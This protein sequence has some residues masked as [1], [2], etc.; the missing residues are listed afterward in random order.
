M[1]IFKT[2][3]DAFVHLFSLRFRL[4]RRTPAA[5]ED[6]NTLFKRKVIELVAY[7]VQNLSYFTTA[8]TH[9]SA[10]DFIDKKTFVSNE[11]LEFLGDAVLDLVVAEYLYKNFAHSDEGKLTKLRSQIVNWKTL[12]QQARDIQL[13]DML[14][15]SDS[16][17]AIGVR[18]SEAAL[19][20]AME[21]FIGAIYLDSDYQN[22]KRFLEERILSRTNFETLQQTDENYK[23]ALLEY[24]QARR[25]A[26]PTY[27]VV[28]EEGPSHKK[29][30]TIAVKIGSE[31][32][33]QGI[34]KSK[35]DAE[36]LAAQEAVS[37]LKSGALQLGAKPLKPDAPPQPL[38]TPPPQTAPT[39]PPQAMLSALPQVAQ[40][41]SESIGENGAAQA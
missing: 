35:K 20:D 23:S 5:P 27:L 39:V 25:L 34:G 3:I 14:I 10:A 11:R 36:Q 9:R 21:A 26:I 30:F 6:A 40:S 4:R 38:G 33:G 29:T 19:A 37:K 7:D 17:N 18:Q 13:G 16:A 28:A 22:T 8:L 24:A 32:V 1:A 41:R 2:L 12:A 31:I 15:V